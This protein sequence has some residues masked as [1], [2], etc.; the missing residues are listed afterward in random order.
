MRFLD[1]E[2]AIFTSKFKNNETEYISK[3]FI[4]NP[5]KALVIKITANGMDKLDLKVK[6]DSEVQHTIK[7]EK[8]C[9]LYVSG[10]APSNV[11]PNY[12]ACE[13]PI[14]YDEKN[15]GMAFCCYLQVTHKG[16]TVSADLDGLKIQEAEEV[17]FYLTAADGY[18]KY[19][20][21]IE[22]NPEV[23]EKSCGDQ[24]QKLNSKTY[25]ELEE[26]HIADYQSVYKNV[27]L[28]LEE[29]EN[30]L[31][32]DERLKRVQNG[33]Q[34]L[35]LSCLF[36][37]YNRYL[38]I[39]CS[40]KGTQPA[41]LQGIWSESIRPV[42]SSNWTININTEMNY[43]LNGPCNLIESFTAFVDF[44]EELSHAGEETAK[45]QCHCSGWTA[46]HN[47]DIWRQTDPVDGEPKYAYWPMGGVW[48][49]SQSYEYYRYSRDLEYL[50]N[51]IYPSLRGSVL[52]C[53]DW[54]QQ[55]EDG[56]YYT[57]PSTS[58]ENTFKDGEGHVCGVSYMTTM[59]LAI[60]KELFANYLEAYKFAENIVITEE[61]EMIK[62]AD[63]TA[64]SDIIDPTV[65]ADKKSLV[66]GQLPVHQ[67]GETFNLE[68]HAE[69]NNGNYINT[70]KVTVRVDKIKVA[71]D[72]QLLDNDK[73]P[74]AWK[75]AVDANGKLVQNHL[76]Y[77]KKGDGVN[78]L[79]S[80]V[81]E[82]NMNQKLLFTTVTY[83][84]T[85]EEELNHMIYMGTLIALS[86]QDDGT[87]TIYMP[88]T[89]AGTDYDYYISDGV[90]KTAEMTY[91]SVQDDYG[92]GKNYIPSLK[93]GESVQVNMAWI[94]N[95]K[96]LEN[97]Y[98]NL[99]DT[100]GCYE[101]SERMCHTGVV[102][103]GKE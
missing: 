53:L 95:E 20:Q 30:D 62:T 4:S 72:L 32:T 29:I 71:D 91:C 70:D 94:V 92:K 34:D 25:K 33:K 55:R 66:N 93:P 43:W 61:D 13:N 74:D 1:L 2:N 73:I 50:K 64:W 48:L 60:I 40:R 8:D 35:G 68:S 101:I 69:D 63:M 80:V 58:P 57:A 11:Q 39:A 65:Y 90:A 44:V 97:L 38:M 27:S 41:N 84:N 24:I 88:G 37:H 56:L 96:D 23:C 19:N 46:N 21:R 49:C 14:V 6:L 83:T 42:W 36:F 17:V 7:T 75:T 79:D 103:V 10:N 47:V 3:M 78:N 99:N 67:I 52:F 82:E 54:L 15:P 102:Y 59:D 16:G 12:I 45:K 100:G 5:A 98:L 76:S 86:K 87:Y 18:K 85:S 28:E 77:M 22:T 9:C 31:P 89:E 81:R 26:E 51:K